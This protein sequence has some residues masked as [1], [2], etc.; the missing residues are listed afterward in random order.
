MK[1]KSVLVTGAT[2][3]IGSHICKHFKTAGWTVIGVDRVRRE[4]TLDYM[5]TFIEAGFCAESVVA[6]LDANMP[7]AVVH[8]AG[9]SLVGPSM[10]DPGEYYTNNVANSAFFFDFLSKH[11]QAPV[12]VFSSSAAVYGAPKTD[13][14]TENT[15]WNPLSPYGQSK[16]MIE[17]ML[18][19]MGRAY[20]LRHVSLRYFNACG[21][22]VMD[23]KLGQAPGATHIIARVLESIRDEKQF[24]LF[25]TDYDTID[26]TCV[27]DYVHV[28]D[29][30]IAHL[31]AVEYLLAGGANRALNLGSGIG[32]SN[33][34]VC[35]AVGQYVGTINY[36]QGPRRPGDPDRLV[37]SNSLALEVL[38]WKPAYSD[39]E[40]IIKTAWKWY[41]NPPES[42]DS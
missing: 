21:A 24:T 19:D 28:D 13:L 4:H 15:P 25:G 26:G 23:A 22:D 40:T 20:G 31:R 6:Y 42:I 29:L 34:G 37:A 30:S 27:R 5:D 11:A 14:I 35:A 9:T 41:N 18:V 8:C 33:A 7:T 3:Y 39:L 16:A 17:L 38:D 36:I 12:V 32:Y 10:T 2:G 1:N